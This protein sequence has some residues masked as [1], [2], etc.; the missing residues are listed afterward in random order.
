MYFC[1]V[2]KLEEPGHLSVDVRD[3]VEKE[4]C[5]EGCEC[6]ELDVGQDDGGLLPQDGLQHGAEGGQHQLV[7]GHGAVLTPEDH[8]AVLTPEDHLTLAHVDTLPHHQ[9]ALVVDLES[10]DIPY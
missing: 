1:M 4:L 9:L 8:G 7:T 2:S 10:H 5:Q 6:P 3:R